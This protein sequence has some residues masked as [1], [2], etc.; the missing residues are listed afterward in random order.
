MVLFVN[1]VCF[2][3]FDS[4]FRIIESVVQIDASGALGLRGV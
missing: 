4:F 1:V 2:A 3:M